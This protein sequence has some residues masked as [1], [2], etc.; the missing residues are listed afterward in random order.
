[1]TFDELVKSLGLDTDENKDK[2]NILKK[3][4]NSKT[5]EVNE[6]TKKYE[7]LNEQL[8]PLKAVEE[9]LGIVKDAFKLDLEADDFDAM[10]D[11]VKESMSKATK[12]DPVNAE[13]L[14]NLKRDITKIT[15]ERDSIAKQHKEVLDQLTT[16]KTNR[17]NQKKV[18]EIRKALDAHKVIKPEQMVDM[19]SSKVIADDDGEIFTIKGA[20]GAELTIS[21]YMSDWVKDNPEF[22]IAEAKGGVGSGSHS[23][24]NTNANNTNGK[25]DGLSPIMQSVLAN[26][27]ANNISSAENM[28]NLFGKK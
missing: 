23:K 28:V 15:R 5:K 4:F 17:I 16:E 18:A 8:E 1:M 24:F 6:L 11:E 26:A 19:F 3:E 12:S 14:K 22:V 10:I 27:N 2:A 21:D 20:D 7:K 13:E 25:N 9:K